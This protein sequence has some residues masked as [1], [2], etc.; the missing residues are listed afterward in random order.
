MLDCLN[1]LAPDFVVL[2]FMCISVLHA[3]MSVRVPALCRQ[4]CVHG[5]QREVSD[6][7]ELEFQTVVGYHVVA[8]NQT[9]VLCKSSQCP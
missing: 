6:A 7:L 5:G 4:C 2:T 1:S 8:R 3:Y 9:W